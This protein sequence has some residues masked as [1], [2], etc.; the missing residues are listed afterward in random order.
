MEGRPLHQRLRRPHDMTRRHT[1]TRTIQVW[2]SGTSYTYRGDPD[3]PASQRSIRNERREAAG[4]PRTG[5]WRKGTPDDW[6]K[7][8]IELRAELYGERDILHCDSALV[9]ALIRQSAEHRM[10]DDAFT[11]EQM[12]NL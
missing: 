4:A 3:G 9:D 6:R 7:I 2:P 8:R 10:L 1:E 5:H 12:R 11:L